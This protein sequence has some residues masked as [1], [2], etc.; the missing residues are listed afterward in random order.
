MQLEM[1]DFAP[2]SATW[3]S[4]PNNV[5]VRL[6]SPSGE[7]DETCMLSLDFFDL[8]LLPPLYENMMSCFHKIRQ[9]R[10]DTHFI[11]S[12][13]WCHREEDFAPVPPPGKT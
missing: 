13:S 9:I 3:Q 10:D 6:V 11:K 8:G 5:V 4:Q 1:A 7:L 2:S 12:A